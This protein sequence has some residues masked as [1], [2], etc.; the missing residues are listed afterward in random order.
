MLHDLRPAT[1]GLIAFSHLGCS[2]TVYLNEGTSRMRTVVSG[3]IFQGM[4]IP[5]KKQRNSAKRP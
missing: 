5:P 4:F 2:N 3:P 1:L